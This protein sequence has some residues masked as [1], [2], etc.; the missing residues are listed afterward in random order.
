[1]Q[2]AELRLLLP[3]NSEVW[4]IDLETRGLRAECDMI[5]GIGFAST[6]GCFYIDLPSLS[7]DCVLYLKEWLLQA[8]LTAYNVMFDGAFLQRFTGKWLRWE[9]CSYALFKS[10]TSEG[11]TG[12]SW[13][14]EVAQLYYL[15]WGHT[16]KADMEYA[17]KEARLSKGDMW[18]LS[19]EILGAY[20]ASDADAAWQLWQ[21]LTTEC[22]T[23]PEFSFVL[24]FHQREFLTSVKLL[25]EQ[26][27][28]GTYIDQER[29]KSCHT[30]LLTDIDCALDAFLTIPEVAHHIGGY[31]AKVLQAWRR[32]AP[33]Q[34]VKSGAVSKRYEVW[35]TRGKTVIRDRGFNPNSKLQLVDLF[36][37]TLGY[38]PLKY[39][40]TG[41]P[42]VNKK[43]LPALGPAGKALN[44]YNLLVKRRG[45]VERLIEKTATDGLLHI[46]F[47]AYGTVTGRLGGSG[48]L[49]AQQMPKDPAFLN[50]W[51]APP[52]EV[53]VQADAES[54]EPTI[55]AEFSRDETLWSL[56][57]PDAKKND[58]YLFVGSK[59]EALAREIRKYYDPE[60]PTPSSIAAAKKNCKRERNIAKTAVLAA[61]YL[62]GPRSIH[63]T[64][65]LGGITTTLKEVKGIHAEYWRLFGGVKL[66]GDD[67]Q[68]MWRESSYFP[69]AFGTP[70][71]LAPH[72]A[73]DAN[74]RFCQTSGH[75]FLQRWLYYTDLLRTERQIVAHPY[76]VDLHD[77]MFWSA[78]KD[79]A[80]AMALAIRD[81][82]DMTNKETGMEVTIRTSVE[83]AE[84]MAVIK[85][86]NYNE[87]LER[88]C[89]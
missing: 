32:S 69:S 22:Q 50:A 71:C 60:N 18:K 12:Q 36:Y 88:Q 34:F 13:A 55:L 46:Q 75:Q 65:T 41:R 4:G 81:A 87:W 76:L 73:K 72:L 43:I 19:P 42:C 26:Q 85:C 44:K 61:A 21:E 56:Y 39:T 35:E 17:L 37:N 28:R 2:L 78:P 62:A 9:G 59:I 20:C 68:G 48:G 63:E 8:R 15:G 14:L 58:I 33:P 1:M 16:N 40:E 49:N 52:G 70:C 74:N 89:T 7:D 57:G 67:L 47:N 54:L 31:N 30:Q 86:E 79:H 10:L 5:Q 27:L 38:K 80:D 25:A 64:L 51:C 23:R 29:L 11:F 82:L 84:N 6:S 66:F 53:L 3:F 24:P 83:I 77:E 45:Y